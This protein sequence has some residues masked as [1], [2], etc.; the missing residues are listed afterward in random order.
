LNRADYTLIGIAVAALMLI[1]VPLGVGIADAQVSVNGTS[2]TSSELE[3]FNGTSATA[4]S[5]TITAFA[6]SF[7]GYQT[8][9]IIS[10]PVNGGEIIFDKVNAGVT[11]YDE[12]GVV[13][14][15]DSYS[16]R[17]SQ[18]NQDNWEHLSTNDATPTT[19]SWIDQYGNI[20]VTYT[21][22][23]S[24]GKFVVEYVITEWTGKIKTTAYFTNY[25]LFNH[26]IAFT[27][28][29][30]LVKDVTINGQVVDL[31]QYV[32]VTFDR[33]TLEANQDIVIEARESVYN[34]GLGFEN[35]WSVSIFDDRVIALDYAN[36]GETQT[37][38][39]ETASLDPT[40]IL[41]PTNVTATQDPTTGQV[42]VSF[43]AP[44]ASDSTGVYFDGS[45]YMFASNITSDWSF[46]TNTSSPWSASFWVK[47]DSTGYGSHERIFANAKDSSTRGIYVVSHN[48]QVG[49]GIAGSNG[50]TEVY[51]Q[52]GAMPR[53]DQ[54]HQV[55][56]TYD[57][58]GN[59][60]SYYLD[61]SLHSTS[62]KNS[63]YWNSAPYSNMHFGA[64]AVDFS[65]KLDGALDEFAIWNSILTPSEVASLYSESTT[66]NDIQTDNV[67]V[68]Y[69]FEESSGSFKNKATG[70]GA[71]TGS[72]NGNS[73]SVDRNVSRVVIAT[74]TAYDVFSKGAGTNYREHTFVN[75]GWDLSGTTYDS[76]SVGA[77]DAHPMGTTFSEDGTKMYVVGRS[78]P[79]VGQWDLTT[80]WDLS[81]ASYTGNTVS[82]SS[83]EGSPTGVEFS[84]DGTKM[85]IV[86]AG[87]DT[88][89]EYGLTTAWDITTASY[90]S[91]SMYIGSSDSI[92][93]ALYFVSD[94]TKLF[95]VGE[96]M[97]T[98]YQWNLTTG[99]D[100]STASLDSNSFNVSSQDTAP[101]GVFFN[102]LGTE[103]YIMGDANETVPIYINHR[104]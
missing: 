16:V 29:L 37:G 96:Q 59:T 85:F 75:E 36:V 13:V 38:I 78:T 97:K 71:V 100:L 44:T 25:T 94:G 76:V 26:K 14:D 65:G 88:V 19:D 43:D 32:G 87:N 91:N 89:Y 33:E 24:A 5:A 20:V 23:D 92:P 49:I 53:D 103:L 2:E 69:D 7:T 51:S 63:A 102:P 1:L 95:I 58:S 68:Y 4:T 60:V 83:Q 39:G 50:T 67:K 101:K 86:G 46:M 81:T 15:S 10:V 6:S 30:Q 64:R 104:S 3:F 48:D 80:A 93:T 79:S 55:T 82:V 45:D 72:I 35:L 12:D 34:S 47:L 90:S 40:I 9:N 70:T 56:I 54:W 98:I 22:E 61:G 8:D 62:A 31:N 17:A 28:T 21:K 11:I 57:K 77:H 74:P 18:L 41:A 73:G 27:E 52:T 99:Y 66:P 84:N 42:T